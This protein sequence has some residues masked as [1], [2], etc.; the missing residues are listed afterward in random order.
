M[1][2]ILSLFFCL[3]C[4]LLVSAQIR[5]N[6]IRVMVSPDRAD[7]KYGLNEKCTFTVRVLKAQNLLPGVTVD[8]ELGPEMYPT[9]TKTGVV[10]KDGKLTLRGTMKTPGFLRCKVK[11][12][13][14]GRTYEGLATAAYA[15]EEL[16]PVSQLPDDFLKF[17]E[18]TLAN[19]R[20]TPLN[21]TMT[22]LPERCTETSN[23]YEVSFQ[24][25]AWGGRMFGI[26][27]VPKAEGTYPA[28]LRVPG[29]GVR[30][31]SGDT[32]LAPGKVIVLEVGIHG[33]PVT[34]QQSVYDNLAAGALNGYWNFCR[35]NRDQNYYNRVIVG[36]LRAVDFIC[37]LPQFNGKALGV[38]GSSQ[39]GALSV[40]TAALDSR[41]TFF[42]TVHPALCDHEAFLK[43]R[44]GGW[45]HYYYQ[46]EPTDKELKALRYYD[47]A[48]FARCLKAIGW[49]SWGYNDEV[50]PPT[51]MYAAYNAVTAPKELHLYLETGHYWYQEQWEE[52]QDWLR[53]QLGL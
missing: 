52:W 5:G 44:A 2:K 4:T 46:A 1:K 40:I 37:S 22:L 53:K 51:S 8:Y 31:Y 3:L 16:R 35:D 33:I 47:T 36:A 43:K 13:V 28:L 21:P 38:T 12:H 48:N 25:K 29:A 26:L 49:F 45:P 19:A 9:E 17:W 32:Y 14:D 34:M 27:S 30:P 11:A 50:C 10:L 24:T 20:Q 41:V 6:E 42:G 23:V 18:T 39:G 7:W 15:P